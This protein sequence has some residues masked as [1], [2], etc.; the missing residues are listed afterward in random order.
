MFVKGLCGRYGLGRG[1]SGDVR[2]G[3]GSGEL[4]HRPNHGGAVVCG[5]GELRRKIRGEGRTI[6]DDSIVGK[7]GCETAS[8]AKTW[9]TSC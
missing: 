3:S 6:L 2:V 9:L 1:L 5:K 4:G 7:E 8:Q